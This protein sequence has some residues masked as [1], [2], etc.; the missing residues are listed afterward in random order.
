MANAR[1]QLAAAAHWLGDN[2]EDLSA[3]LRSAFDALRLYDYAQMHPELS[4]MAD[5]WAAKDRVKALGY[6]PL[7]EPIFHEQM[8]TGASAV[9]MALQA[10]KKLLDSVAFVAKNGDTKKPL[11]LIAKVLA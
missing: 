6:D 4:E 1:E 8:L 10:A 9:A 7:A 3:G 2:D 5:E 11:Q